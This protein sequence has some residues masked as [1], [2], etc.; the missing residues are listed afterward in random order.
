GVLEDGQEL[1]VKK[2]SE[3]SQQGLDEFRNEVICIARL[4]HRNLVK[5]H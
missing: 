1:A 5:L 2:L 3:T 4:Q